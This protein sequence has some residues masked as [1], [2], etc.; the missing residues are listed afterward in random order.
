M[1]A[2]TNRPLR[3]TS[4]VRDYAPPVW[5]VAARVAAGRGSFGYRVFR[6][7]AMADTRAGSPV[8]SGTLPR[9]RR[10]RRCCLQDMATSVLLGGRTYDGVGYAPGGSF[11]ATALKGQRDDDTGRHPFAHR[12]RAHGH[13]KPQPTPGDRQGLDAARV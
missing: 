2:V 9:A 3:S 10:F 8:G 12:P 7:A 5:G 11:A 1:D 6:E 4:S 13:R